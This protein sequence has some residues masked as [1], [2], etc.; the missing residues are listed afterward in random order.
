VRYTTLPPL[1]RAYLEINKALSRLGA[2]PSP[3]A[4]PA[5][6][7]NSLIQLIPEA[8]EPA[9]YLVNKYQE[10]IYSQAPSKPGDVQVA[11]KQIRRKSSIFRYKKLINQIK[12]RFSRFSLRSN[13]NYRVQ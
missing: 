13:I 4:T 5:E 11:G 10:S 8:K 7:A 12:I 6:R 1:A 2:P 9:E 3:S